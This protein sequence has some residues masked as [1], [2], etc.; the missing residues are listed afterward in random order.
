MQ[1]D[2]STY[3]SELSQRLTDAYSMVRNHL[4]SAA[5]RRKTRYDLRTKPA[6][7]APGALVWC[8]RPRR[9]KGRY[10]KWQSLYEGPFTVVQQRG[11][12]NYVIRKN[13]RAQPWVVHADKLKPYRS[14]TDA[15]SPLETPEPQG[16]VETED[17]TESHRP[18]RQHRPPRRYLD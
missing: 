1:S 15:T 12:V 3:A 7:F 9:R 14:A 11:P 16:R 5:L 2:P 13:S 6:R 4:G 18:V 8:L 17:E 10:R